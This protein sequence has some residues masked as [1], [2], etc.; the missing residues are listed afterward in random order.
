M[1]SSIP[2]SSASKRAAAVSRD[3]GHYRRSQYAPVRIGPRMSY[4]SLYHANDERIPIDGFRW[5]PRLYVEVV[6][7]F[8]GLRFD[9]V[10]E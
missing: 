4:R 1:P 10:F 5:E 2:G 6:L 7:S 9:Q 3:D 8:V